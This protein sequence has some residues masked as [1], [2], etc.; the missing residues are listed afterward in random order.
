[1]AQDKITHGRSK[2][3]SNYGGVGS[4]IDTQDCT[5]IIE[6]FDNWKYPKHY[7]KELSPFII[8]DD[9]LLARLKTRFPKLKQLVSVPTEADK[10]EVQVQANHFP[11]WFYCPKCH[12]FKEYK[13]WK[14]KW[15]YAKGKKDGI[16]NFSLQCYN[17]ECDNTD[18]EQ[19]RFVLTCQ[20]GHIQDLPWKYWNNRI[21]IDKN[22]ATDSQAEKGIIEIEGD[23]DEKKY[24]MIDFSKTCCDNQDLRYEISRENTE[25]SGI[26]VSCKNCKKGQSLKGVFNYRQKCNGRK[27]WLGLQVKEGF[28]YE[29]CTCKKKGE[30]G[31]KIKFSNSVYYANTL[32]SIWIPEKQI[33]G[34]SVEMRI[35]IDSIQND[36]DYEFK[37]LEKFARRNNIAIELINQYL[38]QSENTNIPEIV[39]RQAEYDYFLNKEQ[40]ENNEIKFKLIDC[41]DEITHC[42]K[43]VKIDKLK[44]ITVQTSFTRQEPIDVDSILIGDGY[45]YK[46]ARQSVSKNSFDTKLLPAIESYGEGILFILD[47]EKLVQWENQIEVKNRIEIIRD[48]A[49]DSDWL[50]HKIEAEKLTPRKVLIHTLSH[51]IMRELQYVCGYPAA[52]LQERLYVSDTMNGFLI[53]AFDGT[54]GY[55]GGLSNLCNDIPNL[56]K[57]IESAISRASDCSLDPIC[58]ESEGQGV[59]QLNLAA[60]HSCTLMPEVSCEHANLFLDRKLVTGNQ[61]SF[62]LM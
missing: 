18:L 60:C 6:T 25:L 40:P 19:V 9:R 26:R 34:L 13:N 17:K 43:I 7:D 10:K 44:K 14:D 30:I 50:S 37:D 3:I 27:Y 5:I 8:Q 45:Q 2:F 48:N 38:E 49:K 32:S 36:Q 41:R 39:F 24:I 29:E 20:N 11:K 54:D 16:S 15:D 61:I 46:V 55:L 35:D 52:S 47:K 59:A 23:E 51:L 28:S 21:E 12:S 31:V 42:E 57:I 4:L 1:M 33:L 62:F 58:Y 22:E 56:N 53:A